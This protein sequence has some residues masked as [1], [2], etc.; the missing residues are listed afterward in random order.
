MAHPLKPGLACK[1][2]VSCL[3]PL[4]ARLCGFIPMHA[5]KK[6]GTVKKEGPCK[7]K[8]QRRTHKPQKTQG[9]VGKEPDSNL[10]ID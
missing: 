5:I 9:Q 8:K 3:Q 7:T 10:P 2:L 1:P 4:P 6:R